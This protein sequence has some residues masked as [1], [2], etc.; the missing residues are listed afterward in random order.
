[1]ESERE[2][3]VFKFRNEITEKSTHYTFLPLQV[4]CL[5]Q[6]WEYC[7]DG[8]YISYTFT[9]TWNTLSV[10]K[11]NFT[12]L[13][14]CASWILLGQKY[15]QTPP[16]C[17]LGIIPGPFFFPNGAWSGRVIVEPEQEGLWVRPK[18]DVQPFT[19]PK[20]I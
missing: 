5:M 14:A 19:C 16:K 3:R 13:S 15:C 8:S 17:S 18:S 11:P 2:I 12:I 20:L 9:I 4:W 6:R 10:F 1:M 7:M